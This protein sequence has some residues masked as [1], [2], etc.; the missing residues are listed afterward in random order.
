VAIGGV[1]TEWQ[2]KLAV[3]EQDAVLA[4]AKNGGDPDKEFEN[5]L[6]VGEPSELKKRLFLDPEDQM[7]MLAQKKLIE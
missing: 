7:E 3:Q 4:G 5:G 2:Q 1:I 6:N